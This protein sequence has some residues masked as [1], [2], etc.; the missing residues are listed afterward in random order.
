MFTV[1]LLLSGWT[2]PPAPS[3]AAP[4]VSV[5]IWNARE[6]VD[7]AGLQRTWPHVAFKFEYNPLKAT[8]PVVLCVTPAAP[9]VGDPHSYDALAA[10]P[11]VYRFSGVDAIPRLRA[12][13]ALYYAAYVPGE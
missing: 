1:I 13:L 4:G 3:G 11:G 5:T 8:D 2:A 7:A 9:L 10:M 6:A 12:L